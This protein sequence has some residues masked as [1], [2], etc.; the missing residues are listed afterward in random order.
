MSFARALPLVPL[1]VL[2][3]ALV[4]PGAALA[5]D[6]L[7]PVGAAPDVV[8][9]I[10]GGGVSPRTVTIAAGDVVEWRNRDDERHR[11]RS[12]SG[13]AEFDSGDL[14]PG[15]SIRYRFAA[16][17]TYAY[18]DERDDGDTAFH[19]RVVVQAAPGGGPSSGGGSTGSGGATGGGGSAGSAGTATSATVSIGDD[20]FSPTAV[21]IA[22]GGTVTFRNEGGDEHSATS[23]GG[24]PI[25]SGALGGGASYRATF[26]SAGT[27]AFLCIFHSDMRGTVTVV[28]PAGAAATPTPSPTP[29]PTATPSLAPGDAAAAPA[30]VAVEAADLEFRAPTV[31]VAAGGSV[32]WTNVGQA[33]HTVTSTEA[34]FDSGMLEPGATFEQAFPTAGTYAYLCTF[35][36]GMAGSVEVVAVG[37]AG[38]GRE[39]A[40]DARARRRPRRRLR[41]PRAWSGRSRAHRR[42]SPP[43]RRPAWRP[44][45]IRPRWPA[46]SSRSWR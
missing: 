28:A 17:G 5:S 14:E 29:A 7:E 19:G 40:T 6:D 11:M 1:A 25:D 27:F 42:S 46:C 39:W 22:A 9:T 23:S 45:R 15:Q 8:V 13:P 10:D 30:T 35:H 2:A 43:S 33:P 4:M 36:P 26:P 18:L 32:T 37:T 24:G 3:L 21:R 38:R 12:R 44:R 16:A 41:P 20:F 31:R 34:G